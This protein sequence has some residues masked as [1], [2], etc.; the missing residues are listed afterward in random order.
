MKITETMLQAGARSLAAAPND[1]K[2]CFEAMS[3]AAGVDWHETS[4]SLAQQVRYLSKRA[5]YWDK[6]IADTMHT[7]CDY[8]CLRDD[9]S[10]WASHNGVTL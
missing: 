6:L 9:L 7:G 8:P 10:D 2:A 1:A 4:A 3:A 5:G